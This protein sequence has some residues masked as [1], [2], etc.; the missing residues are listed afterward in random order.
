MHLSYYVIKDIF[1]KI[2][3]SQNKQHEVTHTFYGAKSIEKKYLQKIN[4]DTINSE[5][6]KSL[7]KI[8]KVKK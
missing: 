8:Y 7:L 2:N 5:I 6:L 3:E 1:L 4:I